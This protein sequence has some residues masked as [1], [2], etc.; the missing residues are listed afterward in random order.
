MSDPRLKDR[1]SQ[2]ED[3]SPIEGGNEPAVEVTHDEEGNTAV[4]PLGMSKEEA[5]RKKWAE[6]VGS[7]FDERTKPLMGSVEQ[8]K[9]AIEGLN[10]ALAARQTQPEP[11]QAQVDPQV[12]PDFMKIRRRQSEI[13]KLLPGATTQ[14]EIDRLESEYYKLD[15]DAVDAR[16]ARLADERVEHSRRNSPAP[17]PEMAV[18]Q[19]EF[20]DV[21]ANQEAAAWAAAAFQQAV[22]ESRGKPFN[23]M[24]A[25]RRVLSQAGEMWGIRKPALSA[26]RA[27]EQ[28]RFGGA[29]PA[30]G[31]GGNR[32]GAVRLSREQQELARARYSDLEP[33]EADRKWAEAMVRRDPKFFG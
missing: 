30:S 2:V 27:H 16:A 10:A 9:R 29:P 6:R 22:I 17:H 14:Q 7:V 28:A 12:D 21:I 20:P 26:P 23:R 13:M 1:E 4:A 24:E 8:M 18:I 25:H 11:R 3:E 15:Q 5:R 19:S 31:P 33:A 32:G